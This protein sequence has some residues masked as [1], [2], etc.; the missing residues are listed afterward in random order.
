MN[1]KKQKQKKKFRKKNSESLR[2]GLMIYERI[3]L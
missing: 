3:E 2:K 1:E